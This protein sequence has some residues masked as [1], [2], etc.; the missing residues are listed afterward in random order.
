MTQAGVI[1]VSV[2]QQEEGHEQ[3][4]GIVQKLQMVADRAGGIYRG[5]DDGIM[6]R[7][8]SVSVQIPGFR[9]QRVQSLHVR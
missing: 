3:R 7:R 6:H 8:G 4:M 5:H 9:Q 1:Y 2:N